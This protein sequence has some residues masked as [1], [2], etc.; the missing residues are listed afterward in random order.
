MS[1]TETRAVKM[2]FKNVNNKKK[3]EEKER[4]VLV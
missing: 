4:N 2:Q 1:E 3:K